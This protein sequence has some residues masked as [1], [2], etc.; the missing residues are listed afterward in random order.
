MNWEAVGATGEVVGAAAVILTLA[1]LAFQIRSNTRA[2]QAS[3]QYD[4]QVRLSDIS[5]EIGYNPERSALWSKILDETL[6]EEDFGDA[7][8]VEAHW[9]I[10]GILVTYIAGFASYQKG[11]MPEEQWRIDRDFIRRFVALPVVKPI[12]DIEID[13]GIINAEFRKEVL[14][15]VDKAD[16]SIGLRRG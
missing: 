8:L 2:I 10:R 5:F 3:A 16:L 13:Q 15:R 1:F 7:Q 6:S 14:D 9:V 4:I 11:M 12:V